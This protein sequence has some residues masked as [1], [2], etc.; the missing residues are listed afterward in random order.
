MSRVLSKADGLL[1]VKL[2]RQAIVSVFEK[3]DVEISDEDK[4]KFKDPRGVFVTLHKHGKLRGCLGYALSK[5][6]LYESVISAARSAA[7]QDARFIPLTKEEFDKVDVEISLLSEPIMLNNDSP[8]SL[9]KE[10]SVGKD[11]LIIRNENFS[12]LL[13][14][15]VA[16]QG[17]WSSEDF[18]KFGC[19]KLGLHELAW[20]DPD[21]RL[22]KF[23]AQTFDEQ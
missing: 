18:L 12:G 5:K 17:S 11:G 4:A 23:R 14:P 1:L 19:N 22:Y 16:T 6:P 15:Q 2:A 8:S 13:L 21:S 3:Q 10:I 9:L 20:L 7:F